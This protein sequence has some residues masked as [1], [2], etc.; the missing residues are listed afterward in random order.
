MVTLLLIYS[1]L[2]SLYSCVN[3]L[4]FFTG[5]KNKSFF[6]QR[7]LT[8]KLTYARLENEALVCVLGGHLKNDTL[9]QFQLFNQ[10]PLTLFVAY[11]IFWVLLTGCLITH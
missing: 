3:K 2:H 11:V 7:V 4:Q 9:V 10:D 5:L 1:K 8:E 6:F